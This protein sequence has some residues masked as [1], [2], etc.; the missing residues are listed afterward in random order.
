TDRWSGC[1]RP[2]LAYLDDGRRSH[3]AA[4]VSTSAAAMVALRLSRGAGLPVSLLQRCLSGVLA[5]SLVAA[6]A[7]AA[8]KPAAQPPASKGMIAAANPLA[9]EAGLKV[10]RAGGSAVDAAVAVQAVLGL[11]EPQSS[12]LS[13]GAFMTYYDAKTKR[14][15]AYDGRET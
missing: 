15:T 13:G 14:T 9:V 8:P 1:S 7:C 11:V 5:L 3:A 10:L 2:L 6:P 12:G 4:I